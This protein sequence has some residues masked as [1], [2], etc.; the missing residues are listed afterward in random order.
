M[1]RSEIISLINTGSP[2]PVKGFFCR[3]DHEKALRE[4]GE[5]RQRFVRATERARA[6]CPDDERIGRAEKVIATMDTRLSEL[7]TEWSPEN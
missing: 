2:M 3:P 5:L 1:T 7:L 6:Q 4:V